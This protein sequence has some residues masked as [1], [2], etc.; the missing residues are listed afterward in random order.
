MGSE[1]IEGLNK[2]IDLAEKDF[3]GMVIANDGREFSAGANLALLLMYAAEEEWDE[4]DT[5]VR[6]FQNTMM[7]LRYSAIP[8]VSAPHNRVL[9]GEIGRAAGRERVCQYV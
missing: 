7:R 4:I 1:V 6:S 5:M 9:G 8:V 2:A 3:R